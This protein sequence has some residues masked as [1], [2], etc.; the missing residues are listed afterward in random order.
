MGPYMRPIPVGA[1]AAMV[2]SLVVAFVVTP[3]AAVRLLRPRGAPRR[4][5]GGSLHARSIGAMMGRSSRRGRRALVFLGRRRDAALGRDGARAARLVTVKMLP[6]DNKSEFQVIVDMPEGTPLEATARVASA[7]AEAALRRRGR[8][9]RADLRRAPR[10]RTTSTVWCGTTSCGARRTWPTAGEPA[11]AR[12]SAREQSHDD[13]QARARR[14]RCRSRRALGAAHSGAEVP[15]GPPVL[16]TLVAEVYGPDAERRLRAR[17]AGAERSSSRRP[18]WWTSTGTSKTPQPKRRLDVDGEKAAAAGLSSARRGVGRSGWP[19]PARRSGCC[20]IAQAREDVPI[21]VRLPRARRGIARRAAGAA[22]RRPRPVAVGELHTGRAHAGGAEHLSQEPA[23]RDLRHRRRR[24]R[25][26]EPGLR[27]PADEPSHR[28]TAAARGLRRSRSSTPRQP[29]D[30][31]KY[32][33]KWDGEWHITYEVFRDLGLA[34]AAVL[35]LIYMLVVGWFQSFMT[36]LD[37]HG[38]DSVLAR[39]HPAGARARSARSSPRRR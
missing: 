18:A 16:Q 20:T 37:D 17:A 9:R 2:F 3:W 10:R 12:T 6:F 25:H 14:A 1:S 4:G 26:R 36:P 28:A 38:G 22:A 30:T 34:F 24:G 31:P 11:S 5:R 19:A 23:A 15:P 32:A 8:R 29:F 33:M 39:R 13:R 7:L 21:V 35:V 27:H